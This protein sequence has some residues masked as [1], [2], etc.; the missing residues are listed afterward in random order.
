M[1]LL[2]WVFL[3]RD[4]TGADRGGKTAGR[5]CGR[6][7]FR[8]GQPELEGCRALGSEVVETDRQ[9]QEH[10][11]RSLRQRWV[12]KSTTA[13]NLALALAAEGPRLGCWMPI[14]TARRSRVCWASPVSLSRKD[15]K[16]LE[17]MEAYGLQAMSIGFLVDEET[18]M[19]WRG[20]MVTQALEQLLNDTN[21]ANLDYL[22]IDLPPG[23]GD[24][25]L[26]LAQKVPVSGAVI[27]TTLRTS[28][29]WMRAR[30]LRCSRRS[31]CRC[32]V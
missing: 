6:S 26:T 7:L 24:T 13:V 31:R 2:S 15:G 27:V 22:V 5:I 14:F 1:S 18:P 11:C 20:P 10:H 8:R 21:W 4:Q 25:Q 12:G 9:C 28:H 32:W 30:A 3:R 16:S 23:T 17:P 29:C 19:I